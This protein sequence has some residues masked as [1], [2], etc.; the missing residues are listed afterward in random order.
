MAAPWQ[1]QS[2]T[3]GLWL[4]V[5][6]TVFGCT[7]R[8]VTTAVEDQAFLPGPSAAPVVEAAKVIPPASVPPE[9]PTMEKMEPTTPAQREEPKIEAPPP[10]KPPAVE[11][12]R[13]AEQP[14]APP[15]PAP[16][17][18]SAPAVEEVRAAE[19]P[20]TP[21]PRAPA[22]A[23]AVEEM[24]AAEQPVTSPPSAPAAP[25]S[26]EISDVYFD[27]DQFVIRSDARS[28]LEAN[29]TALKT[30]AARAILI[31]GHCD[32]RG[33]S[34][35]NLVLGE[36]RAQAAARYLRDLGVPSSQIQITSYGKERP[37]CAEHSE[38]CWQSNRRAHFTR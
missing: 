2:R 9:P 25:P 38:A 19:Q 11:E 34:A 33:T 8:R 22:P 16:A 35:Y 14:V 30:Q 15:P 36:R 7:G 13:A 23:P 5:L 26:A 20:V 6:T 31:E 27:F 17:P 28:L 37:F 3:L 4:I 21:P 10:A 24:H 18:D 29:A 12:V 1:Q 32:E